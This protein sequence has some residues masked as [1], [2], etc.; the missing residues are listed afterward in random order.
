MA[1]IDKYS[2]QINWSDEDECFIATSDELPHLS[3][4]GNTY[5]E[6][7]Q[8]LQEAMGGYL[9]VL[10]DENKPQPVTLESYSGQFRVRLPR[11][12]HRRLAK[13]ARRENVSLNT[14]VIKL[15]TEASTLTDVS[16]RSIQRS[17][18]D[19]DQVAAESVSE[20]VTKPY[21]P[22]PPEREAK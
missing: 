15:L 20:S 12:L 1:A 17:S 8:E 16:D 7:I 4:F 5:R 2:V 22:G 9:E 21:K 3:A 10:G 6:A 11:S 19:K 13:L 18:S 14:L